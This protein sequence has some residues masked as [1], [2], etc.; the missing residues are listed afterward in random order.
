MR[1]YDCELVRR[2]GNYEL[3]MAITGG[4]Q[5]RVSVTPRCLRV[6][7]DRNTL[8][9]PKSEALVCAR[10]INP[11][12][13]M[14]GILEPTD[15]LIEK[16]ELMLARTLVDTGPGVVTLRVLSPTDQ[17]RMLYKNTVAST[18]EPAEPISM[19]STRNARVASCQP[20]LKRVPVKQHY[21]AVLEHLVELFERSCKDLDPGQRK[22]LAN[23]LSEFSDVFAVSPSDLGRT[24]VACHDIDTGDARP[25]Q[26]PA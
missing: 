23:F 24:D 1:D 10:V 12:C 14:I 6:A 25:I 5:Q 20:T 13:P 18:R 22:D 11:G 26:Q 7:V 3:T 15:R 9:P 2:D 17:T 16:N 21:D 8:I 4:D 19:S